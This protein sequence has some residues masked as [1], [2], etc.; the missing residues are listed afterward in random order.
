MLSFDFDSYRIGIDSMASACMSPFLEDFVTATLHPFTRA[1]GVTPFGK[2]PSITIQQIGTKWSFEDDTGR[3]HHIF[4]KNSLH[5]PDGT[6]RLISPQHWARSA[7]LRGGTPMARAASNIIIKM[8]FV[9]VVRVNINEPYGTTFEA[10]SHTSQPGSGQWHI[11]HTWLA[12]SQFSFSTMA[13]LN[14]SSATPPI[15]I[16][17]HHQL[18]RGI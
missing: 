5:V 16:T 10:T 7:T 14:M 9:S 18:L 15:I 3:N 11:E 17:K 2:G 12:P 1:S 6:E 13:P 8:C 4:I